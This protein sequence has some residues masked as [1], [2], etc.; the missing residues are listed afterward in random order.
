MSFQM[1]SIT[2][3]EIKVQL[4]F[5]K[6]ILISQGKTVDSVKVKLNKDLFMIP[7]R[8]AGTN[9]VKQQ[10]EEPYHFVSDKL[11]KLLSS[12]AEKQMVESFGDSSAYVILTMIVLPVFAGLA[13]KGIM[14]KLWAMLSTF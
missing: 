4:T 1:I 14:S 5:E 3:T 8:F 7:T 12:E 2:S 9:T 6:P 10:D 13:L 11:P